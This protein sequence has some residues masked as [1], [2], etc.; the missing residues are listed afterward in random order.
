MPRAVIRE[1]W[2]LHFGTS[3]SFWH[4]LSSWGSAREAR[5]LRVGLESNSLMVCDSWLM[6]Q[7]SWLMP[8]GSW[9]MAEKNWTENSDFHHCISQGHKYQAPLSFSFCEYVYLLKFLPVLTR[10]ALGNTMQCFLFVEA[11][12]LS[13]LICPCLVANHNQNKN[14]G[15]LKKHPDSGV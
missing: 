9:L 7:G 10:R 4:I 2:R 5:R 8:Q 12:D 1:A 15:K 6:A 11:S 3:G 13:P 14:L